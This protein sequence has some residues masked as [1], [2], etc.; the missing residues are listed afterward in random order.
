MFMAN[1]VYYG[2]YS[3]RHWVDLILSK[4]IRLPEYQRLFVWD[5]DAV[6]TLMKDFKKD[7]F[8]HLLQ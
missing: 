6:K 5:E 4:N 8:F 1:K 2:E 3:L 7:N